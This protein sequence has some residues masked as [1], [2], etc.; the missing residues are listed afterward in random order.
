MDRETQS[1]V[2]EPFFTTK[3]PDPGAGLGLSVVYGVVRQSGGYIQIES[4][5]GAGSTFRVY[6]PLVAGDAAAAATPNLVQ[7]LPRGRETILIAE[8]DTP[9]RMLTANVLKRL[10]YDVVSAPDGRAALELAQSRRGIQLLLTDVVMPGMGGPELATRMK[11]ADPPLHVVFMSG[12]AAHVLSGDELERLGA[13]FLQKPF[14]M[15]VLAKTVRRVLDN[16]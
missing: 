7:A 8:D 14:T 11:A 1:R 10:G 13:C 3:T 6:L 12:Y 4:E 5:P 2:F 15:E 16:V 9:I